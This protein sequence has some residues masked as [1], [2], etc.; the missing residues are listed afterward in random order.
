MKTKF[1]LFTLLLLNACA[2]D[3]D[4]IRYE[5]FE[6]GFTNKTNK[7]YDAQLFIGGF[8]DGIFV[9]TESVEIPKL[10]VGGINLNGSY[11]VNNRWQPNLEAIRAIP[12]EY[13]YFKLQLSEEREA[14]IGVYESS[15]LFK[16]AIPEGKKFIDDEGVIYIYID[17]TVIT[18]RV[19]ETN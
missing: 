17:D 13:A 11:F 1:L 12:S 10:K 9:A 16:L 3:E 18:G 19:L 4:L 7:V 8:K 5:G 15:E 2:F 14:I 6:I